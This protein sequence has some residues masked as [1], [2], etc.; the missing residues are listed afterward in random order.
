MK[1]RPT[2]K[3]CIKKI[4]QQKSKKTLIWKGDM[5][6][7]GVGYLAGKTG[8]DMIKYIIYVCEILKE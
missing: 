6:E 8:V 5:F 3:N 4:K 7:G 1:G 2:Q